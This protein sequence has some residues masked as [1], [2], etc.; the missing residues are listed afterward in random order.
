MSETIKTAVNYFFVMILQMQI[1][2]E[3]HLMKINQE[4]MRKQIL[5][6]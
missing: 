4:L 1:Q 3:I 5:I 6:L 2:T